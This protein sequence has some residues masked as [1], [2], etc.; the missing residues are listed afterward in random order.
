MRQYGSVG[1]CIVVGFGVVALASA[2]YLI[3]EF[4]AIWCML[5]GPWSLTAKAEKCLERGEFDGALKFA[6]RAV[7]CRPDFGMTYDVRPRI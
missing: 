1:R 7:Q 4:D 5:W 6:N 2:C 3:L